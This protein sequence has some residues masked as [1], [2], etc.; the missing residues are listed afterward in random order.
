MIALLKY[1]N[2]PIQGKVGIV[3]GGRYGHKPAF[4][5]YIGKNMCDAVAVGKIFTF[6]PAGCIA[7]IPL[8]AA[9]GGKGVAIVCWKLCRR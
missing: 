9:D 4:V 3:T 1:K 5:G 6:W 8:K 7:K 2:A